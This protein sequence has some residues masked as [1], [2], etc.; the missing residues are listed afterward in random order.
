M[1]IKTVTVQGDGYRSVSHYDGVDVHRIIES[2]QRYLRD[3]QAQSVELYEYRKYGDETLLA[4]YRTTRVDV[5]FDEL[6]D[7]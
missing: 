6:I 2:A 5:D 3:S 1:K 4:V 7:L